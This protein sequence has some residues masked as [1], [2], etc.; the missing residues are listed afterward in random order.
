MEKS[1]VVVFNENRT[2]VCLLC[3]SIVIRHPSNV[4]MVLRAPAVDGSMRKR[5]LVKMT[6]R[7][8]RVR[9]VSDVLF[10]KRKSSRLWRGRSSRI[11]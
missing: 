6:V 11:G 4:K 2:S 1:R 3:S 5:S 9:E 7:L 10:L 8:A